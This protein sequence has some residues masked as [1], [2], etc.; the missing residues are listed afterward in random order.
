[1][2]EI[3]RILISHFNGIWLYLEKEVL[4][5]DRVYYNVLAKYNYSDAVYSFEAELVSGKFPKKQETL[6]KA[7]IY[8]REEELRA[9]LHVWKEDNDI[10]KIDGL[11]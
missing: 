2:N 4:S 11:K 7:W 3:E 8:M 1:M 5:E 10:L 9:A 6:V